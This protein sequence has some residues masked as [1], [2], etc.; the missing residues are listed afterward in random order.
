VGE[1]SAALEA[2]L[3]SSNRPLKLR[4]LQQATDSD[5]TAVEQALEELRKALEVLRTGLTQKDLFSIARAGET[6]GH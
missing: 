1:V 3:F 6:P 4:E 5:R 2:I